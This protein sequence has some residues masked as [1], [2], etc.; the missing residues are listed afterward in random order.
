MAQKGSRSP[1]YLSTCLLAGASLSLDVE[2]SRLEFCHL[3]GHYRTLITLVAQAA[4]TTILS[5][6]QI[7][8]GEQAIDYWDVTSGVEASNTIGHPLAD[9]VE[10]GSLATNDASQNDD[11]IVADIWCAP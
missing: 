7:V 3:D 9:I 5:L 4:S 6:L 11:G 10:V 2:P 8:G 1:V